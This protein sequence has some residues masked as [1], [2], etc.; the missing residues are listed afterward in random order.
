[1]FFAPASPQSVT[2]FWTSY[3][4][5]RMSKREQL[6]RAIKIT[7]ARTMKQGQVIDVTAM[8]IRLSSKY[9]QS[10]VA[11][12]AICGQIEAAVAAKRAEIESPRAV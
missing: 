12:D 10:G 4:E 1:V 6:E 5:H 2:V 3:R 9:Q 11:L 7:V 8:A